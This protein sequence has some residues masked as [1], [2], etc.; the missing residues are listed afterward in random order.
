M[1]KDS[2]GIGG[3][4][5]GG[6]V[7]KLNKQIDEA[8]KNGDYFSVARDIVNEMQVGESVTVKNYQ[9]GAMMKFEKLSNSSSISAFKNVLG[10]NHMASPEHVVSWIK[11]S[12]TYAGFKPIFTKSAKKK[13]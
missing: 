10:V 2:S 8:I 5:G 11:D 1:A 4:G 13:K 9:N 12:I 6:H 3:G 7:A